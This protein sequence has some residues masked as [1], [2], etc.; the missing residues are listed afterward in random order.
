LGEAWTNV[1]PVSGR[2][3]G[4]GGGR[5]RRRDSKRRA[6]VAVG[7]HSAVAFLTAMLLVG[8]VN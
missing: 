2:G 4:G 7:A 6:V 3:G 5:K 8:W 1:K